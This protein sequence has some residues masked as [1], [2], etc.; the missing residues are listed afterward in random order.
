[1]RSECEELFYTCGAYFDLTDKDK[2]EKLAVDMLV[3]MK[4]R[5]IIVHNNIINLCVK[6]IEYKTN[7][8]DGKFMRGYTSGIRAANEGRKKTH[9]D[10]IAELTK[11]IE[12]LKLNLL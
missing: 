3:S 11:D 7:E 8:Y 9:E 4:Q 5:E 10:Y 1:M 6:G 12:I 2:A